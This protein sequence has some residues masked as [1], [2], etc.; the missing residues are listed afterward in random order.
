MYI[1]KYGH[2]VCDIARS[3]CVCTSGS[4]Q[5]IMKFYCDAIRI[6]YILCTLLF[7]YSNGNKENIN[8]NI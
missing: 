3:V 7:N 4:R 8:I 1:N 2:K 6:D 5:S